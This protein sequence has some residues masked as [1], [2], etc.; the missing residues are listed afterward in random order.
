[1]K[2][3]PKRRRSRRFCRWAAA[4]AAGVM[5]LMWG[6]TGQ[7]ARTGTVA[8]GNINVRTEASTDSE[9]VCK[10]PGNTQVS[11]VDETTGSDGMAWYSVTF[12][13]EGQEKSGWIRSDMLTVSETEEPSGEE[14]AEGGSEGGVAAVGGYSIQEPVE[15]YPASNALSQTTIPVGEQSYTAWVVDAGI[16]GGRE[17]YLVWAVDAGGN[18]GWFYYDPQDGTFQREMGQFSGGGSGEPE[19]MI[20]SLQGELAGLKEETEKSLSQRL[21]A[22]IGLGVLSAVL[23]I[24]VVVLSVKLR[25]SEYEYY[26]DDEDEEDDEDD[27][28]Y[29]DEPKKK[30][31]GFFRRRSRDEEDEDDADTEGSDFDDLLVAVRKKWAEEEAQETRGNDIREDDEEDIFEEPAE[32]E[33]EEDEE[34]MF[35]TKKLP[36]IDMSTVLEIEEEAAKEK[37]K[38]KPQSKK[39][40]AKEPEPAPAEDEDDDLDIEIL[41]FEDL[42]I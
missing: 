33:I 8:A 2:K 26:D 24:L 14:G 21:Y 22:I 31:G 42:G 41:D 30:K 9:R 23:L 40:Q 17:L 38:K 6:I 39:P 12:T 11:V 20:E 28:Y 29:D 18:Q 15:T 5:V 35:S 25:N 32:E 3:L 34:E 1:M 19:G 4:C 13:L 7:A 10:L 36:K 27:T 37:Q 16:T